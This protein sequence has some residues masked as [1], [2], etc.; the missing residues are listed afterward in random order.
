MSGR[1]NLPLALSAGQDPKGLYRK[2]FA[3]SKYGILI[4]VPRQSET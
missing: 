4:S 3:P 1:L 2:Q